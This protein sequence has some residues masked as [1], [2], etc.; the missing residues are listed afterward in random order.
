M[1]PYLLI[2]EEEWKNIM[3]TYEKEDVVEELAKVLHTY[4]A[5]LPEITNKQTLDSLNKLKGIKHNDVLVEKRWF[6]RNERKSNYHLNYKDSQY[7]LKRNNSGNNASNPFHVETRWKVDWTR[8]PS[9]W[10][11]WQTV[12][13]IKTIVRAY[14]T[15]DKVLNQVDVNTLRVATTLRKYVASQFKPAVAKAFYD[16]FQSRNVLDFSA[17]WGDRLAGFYT[18]ETTEHYVGIDPNALNHPNYQKQIQFY[19]KYSTFFEQDRKADL[20]ESP[21]E[22]VDYSQYENYFD[23]VF[24]SPPYFNTER[25]SDEE[26]QSYLKFPTYEEWSSGFLQQ[27]LRNVN[28]GLKKGGHL[29]LNIAN[30]GRFPIEEDSVRLGKKVGLKFKGEIK[31]SLSALNAGGFKYEPIFIFSKER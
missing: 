4:P 20:I 12:N 13:G 7:L 11:T 5:P 29:L 27:T 28:R 18:G 2:E 26:T 19:E 14:W 10:K 21:A 16:H 1:K 23:T 24:T 30:A 6:P 8:T 17:G 15:L 31:L 25:Y 22:D 3:Q 9:G